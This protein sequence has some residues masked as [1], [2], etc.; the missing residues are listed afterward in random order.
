[1]SNNIEAADPSGLHAAGSHVPS[2]EYGKTRG[3]TS[4][5]TEK[6]VRIRYALMVSH[7][8]S[9]HLRTWQDEIHLPH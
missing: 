6:G 9:V 7:V 3:Y 2:A 5:Y 8:V 1:M 4:T